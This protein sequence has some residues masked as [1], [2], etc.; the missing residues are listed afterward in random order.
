MIMSLACSLSS[1]LQIQDESDMVYQ[2]MQKSYMC[3]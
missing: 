3:M 1:E 2:I